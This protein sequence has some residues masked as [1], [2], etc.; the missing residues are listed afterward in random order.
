MADYSVTYDQLDT[1]LQELDPNTADTPYEIEITVVTIDFLLGGGD[2]PF[3]GTLRYVLCQNLSKFVSINWGE[4]AIRVIENIND[5]MWNFVMGAS[6]LVSID[7]SH[8][9]SLTGIRQ[10]FPR[11]TALKNLD[12][13]NLTQLSYISHLAGECTSLES[14]NLSGLTNLQIIDFSFIRCSNL[15]YV[16]LTGCNNIESSPLLFYGCSALKSIILPNMKKNRDVRGMFSGCTS[17]EEIHNWTVPVEADYGYVSYS[18][19]L[20]CFAECTSLLAIYTSPSDTPPQEDT[21]RTW[22]IKK[23]TANSRSEVMIY[24]TSGS[25]VA[26]QV[27]SSGAYTL[28][29]SAKVD[30]LLFS[31][32]SAITST[33]IQKMLQT[34]APITGNVNTLDPTKDNFLMLAKDRTAVKTNI[35]TDVVEAGNLLPP[36]SAAV[37]AAIGSSGLP[38]GAIVPFFGPAPNLEWLEC[39]GTDTTGTS[40]ELQTHYPALYS[41]LGNTNVLPDLR[42]CSLVGVGKN[43]TYVFDSTELD[44]A[45]GTQGSQDHDVYTVGEF[46]DDQFQGHRHQSNN[47]YCNDG[48]ERYGGNIGNGISSTTGYVYSDIISAQTSVNNGIPRYGTT[49]HGKRLGVTYCI[50]AV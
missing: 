4:D 26:V 30:E 36:T 33:H 1:L 48:A 11:C 23:D 20:R 5:S 16:N 42:E 50:K 6:N 34:K 24:G 22:D 41:Y 2:N 18:E 47:R 32:D 19:D 7:M 8:F 14:V 9:I 49:T 28:E 17:L 38:V 44:P 31:A 39:D 13:S 27:P 35:T 43:E 21:W 10:P 15:K 25:S 12:L 46:K 37:H 40:R 3:P 45:T 29:V